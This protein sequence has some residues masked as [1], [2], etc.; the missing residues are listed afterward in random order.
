MEKDGMEI[1]NYEST[2]RPTTGTQEKAFPAQKK[3]RR[4]R[5]AIQ[6]EALQNQPLNYL[7]RVFNIL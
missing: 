4:K 2:R 7:Q 5:R 6:G 3:A 1:P